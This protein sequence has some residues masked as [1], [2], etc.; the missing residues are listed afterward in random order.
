MKK[1]YI[2]S[3]FIYH[4]STEIQAESEEEAKN[5]WEQLSMEQIV[6]YDSVS[7][8]DLEDGLIVGIDEDSYN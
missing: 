6:G 4:T 7:L 5:I 3:E 1:Y 8:E 2:T